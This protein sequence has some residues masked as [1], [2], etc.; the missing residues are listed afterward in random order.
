MRALRWYGKGDVR[1]ER[2]SDPEIIN[3]RDAIVRVTR[4]AICGSDLHLYGGYIPTM[5]KG[6][7]L[8]H[9]F[10]G[11]VVDVG[12]SVRDLRIGDRV[13]VPFTISCGACYY[14]KS[15]LWS[16][17]DNTNPNA[18]MAEA[19]WGHSSAGIYGYSHMLGG[20]S[21][22]QAEY[23]RVPFA[24]VG[25]V[26]IESDID[27]EHV[28]FLTDIFPTGYMAAEN[29]NIKRGDVI[30]VFGCGPVGQFAIKSAFM[31]GAERVIAVDRFPERLALAQRE[32]GAEII[33]YEQERVL[34]V[35]D[36]L[37]GGRGPDACIDA[38][39]LEAHGADFTGLYD[40]VK[41][42]ARLQTDRPTALRYAIMAC[43]S[44]GTVSTPGVYGGLLDKVPFGAVFSKAL[45]IKTGQTHMHRY[46]RP[47]LR[48]VESGEI[49]PAF[50][51]T[52]RFK[53]EDAPMAYEMFRDKENG[54]IKVVLQP[55]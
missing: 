9:E 25:C 23:V 24:D 49:D 7:I 19:M 33:N 4:T 31:L 35:I 39:G 15:E 8:G 22:G 17:C 1:V 18:W 54:C 47:L 6:D 5:R 44:G 30:A 28:L 20:Y 45:T 34:E 27:D 38:V 3:P 36:E 43:R 48:R 13:L 46:M 51:I 40:R 12:K 37:T 29:C 42:A 2:V 26:K 50:I 53:L 52:H 41:Q 16:L 21:G 32:G 14:C 10:M 55:S 11:E